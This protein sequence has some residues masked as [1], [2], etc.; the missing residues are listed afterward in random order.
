MYKDGYELMAWVMFDALGKAGL[1]ET[2]PSGR[3]AELLE[4]YRL[5]SP[6]VRAADGR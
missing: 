3:Y 6:A 4:A 2:S 1:L 5:P